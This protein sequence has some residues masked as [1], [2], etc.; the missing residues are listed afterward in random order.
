MY[1]VTPLEKQSMKIYEDTSSLKVMML[2]SFVA[3][4]LMHI[5]DTKA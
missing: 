4:L 2:D 3:Y 5:K 1:T